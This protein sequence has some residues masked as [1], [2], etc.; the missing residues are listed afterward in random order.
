MPAAKSALVRKGYS[1]IAKA[2]HKQ[3]GRYE[4][5]VL[6][7][8]FSKLLPTGSTVIDLGCGAGVPVA[9]FLVNKKYDIT[10]IDFAEGM[11]RLAK[12]NVPKAKFIRMDITKMKFKPNSFDG[13]VSFYTLI[14]IPREKHA[15]IYKKLHRIIKPDGIAL[16]NASGIDA[17]GWEE[18]QENYLGVPMFWSFYSPKKTSKI[19]S[20]AGFDILWGRILDI[21][22]EKQFWVLARNRK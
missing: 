13:A 10:G 9:K 22:N 17:N 6:L 15:G 7:A 5:K 19:I 11:V 1:K 3:R 8:K 4:S 14:H 2:Y 12:K 20:D 16:L 18:Y 21:G